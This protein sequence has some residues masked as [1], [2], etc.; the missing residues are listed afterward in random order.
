MLDRLAAELKDGPPVLVGVATPNPH[1]MG[2]PLF[3]SAVLLRGGAAGPAFHKTLLPTYDV[4]DEDRYFEPATGPQIL[5]W[6]GRRLGISICEDV[7]NDRDFWQRRRYH[8]DPIEELAQAGAQAIVNMSASPFTVGKQHLR[9]EMLGHMARKYGLPVAYVNQVG[10]N[11][12]L[13]FDGRSGAFDPQGRLFAR[14]KGFEEDVLLVDL[15]AE[16]WRDRRR[17]FRA[18]GRDL[19]RAGAGR[20]RLRPED[21]LQPGAAGPLGRRRFRAYGGHRRRCAGPGKRARRDDALALLKQRQRGRFRRAG[22]KPRHRD[23]RAADRTNRQDLRSDAGRRL[24]RPA[25]RT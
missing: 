19:A 24:S 7:W 6:G 17:R 15:S 2:R 22:A 20:P 14:A 18:R 5:E 21:R 13:I 3:N 11:D 25:R 4:F 23:P 16:R 1:E 8:D 9:E 10:G 12:D